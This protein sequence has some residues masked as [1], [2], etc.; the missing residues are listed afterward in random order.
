MNNIWEHAFLLKQQPSGKVCVE[1]MQSNSIIELGLNDL[2]FQIF[3]NNQAMYHIDRIF[4]ITSDPYVLHVWNFHFHNEN[5][6]I[7]ISTLTSFHSLFINLLKNMQDY[8][9]NVDKNQ[10]ATCRFN[11]IMSFI[12][13]WLINEN[14]Q[15]SALGINGPG[16]Y[17]ASDIGFSSFE[18]SL[19]F[20]SKT[21]YV[22]LWKSVIL[23]N[24][25]LIISENV[26][27]IAPAVFSV[28]GLSSPFEYKGKYL[29]T[30]NQYDKRIS[31]NRLNYS[32]VGVVGKNIK[33]AEFQKYFSNIIKVEP[34]SGKLNDTIIV[35]KKMKLLYDE[36]CVISDRNLE[37]D[38]YYELL[39]KRIITPD[40]DAII[41]D[42]MKQ[43]TLTV[44]EL[45]TLETTETFQYWLHQRIYRS[46][47]RNSFLS[48][49]PS[50]TVNSLSDD[51]LDKAYGHIIA[52]RKLF[53]NDF[54]FQ[55]VLRKHKTLIA[56]RIGMNNV[57][58]YSSDSSLSSS[59]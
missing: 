4:A 28:I 43:K 36:I 46:N 37:N 44:P 12:S 27:D 33:T 26:E 3:I 38:P 20:N 39:N 48:V 5:Y 22:S 41:C 34:N 51:D 6:A 56:R 50:E 58:S 53:Q 24:R 57:H 54:H 31:N 7:V 45:M 1:Q 47:L 15:V 59:L 11:I 17:S 9:G 29:I 13:S 8:F 35:H 21:D 49:I 40:L 18:P 2:I 42:K 25:I 16:I 55:H 19:Y 10:D 32:I 14:N 30:T 23:N 52:L